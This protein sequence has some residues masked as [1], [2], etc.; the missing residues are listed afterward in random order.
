[1]YPLL[2]LANVTQ[3]CLYS[4]PWLSQ[5]TISSM[6]SWTVSDFLTSYLQQWVKY[7]PHSRSSIK[8]LNECIHECTWQVRLD[9]WRLKS[10]LYH[11]L[12]MW[13]WPKDLIYLE[14]TSESVFTLF[15]KG[16]V[17]IREHV[18]QAYNRQ[19][20][21]S[22]SFLL[23]P[24]MV[25]HLEPVEEISYKYET[26]KSLLP[27][28]LKKKGLCPR[29]CTRR[30]LLWRSSGCAPSQRVTVLWGQGATHTHSLCPTSSQY[31]V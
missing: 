23:T 18:C 4:V 25:V 26:F 1:M 17:Q 9:R 6:R 29:L 3:K 14:C 10:Q 5:E 15:L 22:V 21:N 27:I 19:E 20:V 30:V 7:L 13:P 11:L 8:Q 31:S 28:G 12:V 2:P 16:H 24:L